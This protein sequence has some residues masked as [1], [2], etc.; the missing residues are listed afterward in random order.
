M[1]CLRA[2]LLTC[3]GRRGAH[4]SQHKGA[5][6]TYILECLF[7]CEISCK[8]FQGGLASDQLPAVDAGQPGDD[9]GDSRWLTGV[10]AG[11]KAHQ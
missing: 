2:G 8:K 4:F 3:Q 1:T 5:S 9:T 10:A 7:C 6:K 11:R